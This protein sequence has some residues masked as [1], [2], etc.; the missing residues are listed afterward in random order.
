MIKSIIIDSD[1]EASQQLQSLLLGDF[2]KK[3]L[4]LEICKSLEAGIQAIKKHYPD[5]VFLDVHMTNEDG[6]RLYTYF[7]SINFEVIITSAN[8]DYT[9]EAIRNSVLDYLLKPINYLEI[10]SAIKRFEERKLFL[11][12]AKQLKCFNLQDT[13]INKVALPTHNG[14]NLIELSDIIYCQAESNYCKV[15][16]FGDKEFLVSKTLKYVEELLGSV[17]F[18][19]IHKSFLVNLNYVEKY[20]TNHELKLTLVNNVELPVSIRKKEQFLHAIL[21]KNTAD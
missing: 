6:F 12:K 3:V 19:R 10:L 1:I 14:Y 13:L 15:V 2:S 9:I 7:E 4:V 17:L 5:I 18:L 20:D 8:T 11:N 16:C 21:Q